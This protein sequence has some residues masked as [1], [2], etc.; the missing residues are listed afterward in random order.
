MAEA[1]EKVVGYVACLVS[2][3]MGHLDS[4]AV[5]D[6]FRGKGIGKKL[7]NFIVNYFQKKKVEIIELEVRPENKKVIEW[8]QRLGFKI[9]KRIK[10]YFP[11]NGDAYLMRKNL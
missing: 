1:S 10:D 4:I 5:E 2:D 6:D 11:D 9:V 8:Y 7:Y 3:G